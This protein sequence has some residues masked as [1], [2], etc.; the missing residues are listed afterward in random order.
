MK[1]LQL[2]QRSQEWFQARLGVI[3]GSRAK[4]VFAKNNIPFIDE[5]IAERLTGTIPESFTSKAM[6]H[7][8]LFEPEAVRAYE[9]IKGYEVQE[10]GFCVHDD[11]PFIA[12]SPDGLIKQGKDYV[13][14]VEIKCPNSKKHV[15]Y[16][17]I[18]RV[19]AEYKPQVVHY[20]VVIETLQWVDFV[21]YDPRMRT[22]RIHTHRVTREDLLEDINTALETYLEFYD[23]LRKYERAIKGE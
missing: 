23:K 1:E 9:Q 7:G 3:T 2:Q 16:I 21:S 19:P 20:F 22:S 15:E 11:Y 12:V 13:G 18:N 6:E 17:R 14:G 4:Q 5:L 8:I 10:V